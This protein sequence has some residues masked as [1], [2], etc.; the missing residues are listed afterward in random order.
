MICT[1]YRLY[2]F[3]GIPDSV[4]FS[5]VLMPYLFPRMTTCKSNEDCTGDLKCFRHDDRGLCMDETKDCSKKGREDCSRW[6]AWGTEECCNGRHCCSLEYFHQLKKLPCVN[7]LGCSNLGYG[8]FCCPPRGNT[9]EPSICC[10]EDP[11]L[12]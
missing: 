12:Q 1:L 2:R 11:K 8:N 6:S 3:L 9:T 5:L 7:H 10:N 4:R